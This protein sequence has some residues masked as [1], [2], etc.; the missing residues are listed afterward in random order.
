MKHFF[1][2]SCKILNLFTSTIFVLPDTY[3]WFPKDMRSILVLTTFY[4]KLVLSY[5]FVISIA[6][7]SLV[8]IVLHHKMKFQPE[9][10]TYLSTVG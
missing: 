3:N 4:G 2:K 5:T 6:V 7:V 10:D 8:K 9:H 1:F